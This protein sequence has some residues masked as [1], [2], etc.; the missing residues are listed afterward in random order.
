MNLLA[1]GGS[2]SQTRGTLTDCDLLLILRTVCFLY[3]KYYQ[4]CLWQGH[5]VNGMRAYPFSLV[6][7]FVSF[8]S[9]IFPYLHFSIPF[10]SWVV[11]A[12]MD[13]RK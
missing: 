7:T 6:I 2:R 8:H 13:A 9:S 5:R 10:S 12:D 1:Y 3:L 4:D 11:M